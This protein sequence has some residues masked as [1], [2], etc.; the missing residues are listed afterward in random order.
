MPTQSPL[1]W[2]LLSTANIN[3]P[4][5]QALRASSR[6]TLVA[7]ASRDVEKANAYAAEHQIEKAFGS[8]EAMLA[9]PDVD[10]VYISLP[11]SLHAEWAIKALNAGKHV[12]CEKPLANTVEDVD[13]MF[14]AAKANHKVLAEAFMYRHHPQTLA[15]KDLIASGAIGE[16][17]LIRGAFSFPI[18]DEADIRLNPNLGGGS[19]WDVGCYPISYARTL[20]GAE[21]TE[22][23]GA[24]MLGKSGV[25]DTFAGLMRW[26]DVVSG[27]DSR[28][29]IIAQFDSSLRA[30]FRTH[31]EIV[32]SNGIITIPQPFKP[33]ARAEIM[34]GES[35]DKFETVII[36]GPE[37][38]YLGEIEDMADAVLEGKAPRITHEDSRNNVKTI[39]AL[40]RSATAHLRIALR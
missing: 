38:L 34:I 14:A 1:R 4:V 5:I 28:R 12:L 21:P 9:S 20:I 16:I 30:P 36:E 24:A 2:G 18:G 32:G 15:V 8:Y 10:V 25:D 40:L 26:Q 7:I 11:N 29:D 39:Q 33:G 13:A 19:I 3:Q 17:K 31:M 22:V 37:H 27:R 23:Y 35:F 6:N